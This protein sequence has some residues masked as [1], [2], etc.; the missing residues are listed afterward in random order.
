MNAM[1]VPTDRIEEERRHL[2][3][4]LDTGTCCYE[5]MRQKKDGAMVYVVISN[6]AIYDE[7]GED[8]V[9]FPVGISLSPLNTKEGTL[10][11]SA[12]RD[13]SERKHIERTLY[14]KNIELENGNLASLLPKPRACISR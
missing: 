9:E 11:M 5:S 10:V 7:H 14:E 8:G 4:L 6:K 2:Q 12:V 1:L 13:S 3:E